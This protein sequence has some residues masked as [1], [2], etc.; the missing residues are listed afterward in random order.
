MPNKDR[1]RQQRQWEKENAVIQQYRRHGPQ[2]KAA[3]RAKGCVLPFYELLDS[4][5]EA[6]GNLVAWAKQEFHT[7]H[8]VYETE[9]DI[10]KTK[11]GKEHLRLPESWEQVIFDCK[12]SPE[13]ASYNDPD[14]KA[15]LRGGTTAYRDS[16]GGLHT[17]VEVGKNPPVRWEHKEYKYLFKIPLLLHELGHVKDMENRVCF[18]VDTKTVDL[19][20]AEVYANIFSLTECFRRGYFMSAEMFYDSL[21]GYKNDTA[22]RGEIVRRLFERFQK[23]DYKKW[24]D[25]EIEPR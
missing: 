21:A 25:Y 18:N 23:P 19:I 3:L 22:Y 2:M 10:L 8:E 17:V 13:I 9:H 5:E 12:D 20:E 7:L 24:I 14:D 6:F 11:K 1:E 4:S 15:N 16:E